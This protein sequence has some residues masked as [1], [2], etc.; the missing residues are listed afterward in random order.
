MDVNEYKI[1][2]TND[3][4]EFV[5]VK[6][7]DFLEHFE[8]A[9]NDLEF[10]ICLFSEDCNSLEI[11]FNQLERRLYE[12]L[13]NLARGNKALLDFF[14]THFDLYNDDK[15]PFFWE[16][17]SKKFLQEDRKRLNILTSLENFVMENRQEK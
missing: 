8:R 14:D 9:R 12:I 15:G 11:P 10:C 5:R 17:K 13:D 16:N 6:I 2:I 3:E 4:K 7:E 1:K